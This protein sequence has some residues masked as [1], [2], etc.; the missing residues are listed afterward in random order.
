MTM[1]LKDYQI[2]KLHLTRSKAGV[3][4]LKTISETTL[5]KAGGYG[6]DKTGACFKDL[7]KKLGFNVSDICYTKFDFDLFNYSTEQANQFLQENKID[8]KIN[9][10]TEV[11]NKI[12]F[13][14]LS[15]TN[16]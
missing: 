8:Y 9:Y 2:L 3:V 15:K 16:N 12:S 5:A 4:R 10:K 7:F 6:Y 1:N 13:I 14:E 11:N